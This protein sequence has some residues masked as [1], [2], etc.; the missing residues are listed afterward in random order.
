VESTNIRG[1]ILK[2]RSFRG[3]N[4]SNGKVETADFLAFADGSRRGV[5]ARER[6]PMGER[7]NF[8]KLMTWAIP[9]VPNHSILRCRRLT[10]ECQWK[11]CL[12][13]GHKKAAA[14]AAAF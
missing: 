9:H 3:M 8:S 11:G 10:R 2:S 1:D 5:P 13:P 7:L 6:A 12:N 14:E 4:H